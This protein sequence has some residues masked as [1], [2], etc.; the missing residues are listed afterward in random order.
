MF[1]YNLVNFNIIFLIHHKDVGNLET[2]S[3]ISEGYWLDPVHQTNIEMTFIFDDY[4]DRYTFFKFKK[5]TVRFKILKIRWTK[6][7]PEVSSSIYSNMNV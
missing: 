1:Y 4:F 6:I 5:M 7:F 3:L 2:S